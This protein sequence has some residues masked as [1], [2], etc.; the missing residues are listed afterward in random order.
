[1]NILKNHDASKSEA[2]FLKDLSMNPDFITP[3]LLSCSTRNAKFSTIAIQCLNKLILARAIP[4]SKLDLLLDAFIEATH[5]AID[6]QLKVLQTLPTLFQIYGQFINNGLVAKLLLICSMLQSPGKIPMVINTSAATQQQI[7]LSLFDKVIEEDKTDVVKEFTVSIDENEKLQISSNAYDAYHV[8]NDLCSL[9][10]HQKPSFLTFK[11]MPETF[12]FELLENV[13]INYQDVF[14]S[15]VE[16]G[17]LVRTR[18]TPLL[19]RSFSNHKDFLIVVRVSRIMLLLIRT[20]IS[21]L[22]LEAEVMLSLLT[23]VV[24]KDSNVPYWKKVLSLEVFDGILSD[25]DLTKYIFSSYDYH[26]DK[27]KLIYNFLSVCSDIVKEGWATKL[28]QISDIV[29]LP[30]QEHAISAQNSSL[31][32]PYIEL[33][34]KNEAPPAPKTYTL[35]LILSCAN[36]ISEG[37]GNHVRSLSTDDS[38]TFTFL[39]ELPSDEKEKNN[40]LQLKA[41][42]TANAKSIISIGAEFLYSSLGNE[43]FHALIRALQKLCHAAG[44]LGLTAERDSL[45]LLFSVATISNNVKQH[46]K[47]LSIGET[48]VETFNNTIV[49]TPTTPHAPAIPKFHQRYLNS[50]H[51][52]CFR[53]LVSLV[54]SLGPTLK[55][56]WGF[57]LATFQ[58]FD[59]Y[60]NGPSATLSF[61][62]IPQKPD[63]SNNDLKIAESSFAKLFESTADYESEA[64]HEA[65]EE[66]I[67]LTR[68]AAFDKIINTEPMLEDDILLCPY[69]RDFFVKR[70]GDISRVNAK[71]LLGSEHEFWSMVVKILSDICTS[72][73][74]SPGLRVTSCSTFNLTAKN[75]A[76][77]AF[78]SDSTFD[79]NHIETELM[80]SLANL[81]DRMLTSVGD[82]QFSSSESEIFHDTLKTLYELLDRFGT[83]LSHSWEA[84]V[85]IVDCPFKFFEVSKNVSSQK[86]LLKSSFEN[87]QLVLNDF[88]QT[89]PL[90]TMI[91][92]IDVLQSFCTQQYELNISF[93]AISYYWL[94][95]DYFRQSSN[96]ESKTETNVSSRDDLLEIIRSTPDNY[97]QVHCLW[98]YLLNSLVK[99]SNDPRSEVRNG[100]MQ[101][102]FR[103][104]DSH[105]SYLDWDKTYDI[106]VKELLQIELNGTFA[107]EA[108]R[109]AAYKDSVSIVLKGLTELYCRFFKFSSEVVYWNGLLEFFQRLVN[110][111]VTEISFFVYK[112]FH[113]IVTALDKVSTEV[114]DLLYSF[115]GSQHI[116][117]VV[118]DTDAYQNCVVELIES[119]GQLY[120]FSHISISQLESGL[121]IFNNAIR[122]PFLPRF[123]KDV[124]KPTKLQSAVIES[125]QVIDSSKN[126]E[127]LSLLLLHMA[128]IVLLPFQT[129]SRIVKKLQGKGKLEVPSFIA[130]SNEALIWIEHIL[131]SVEDFEPLV[132]NKSSQ[133]VFKNLLEAVQSK[134]DDEVHQANILDRTLWK[135]ALK[136]LLLLSSKAAPLLSKEESDEEEKQMSRELWEHIA[137]SIVVS[138]PVGNNDRDEVFNEDIYQRFKKSIS[139]YIGKAEVPESVLNKLITSVWKSSFLYENDEIEKYLLKKYESPVDVSRSLLSTHFNDYTTETIKVLPQ[140][141]LRTLCLEDLFIFSKYENES[142]VISSEDIKRISSKTLPYLVCRL[143]L[144][145]KKFAGSQ[146][147]LHYAPVPLVQQKEL[148]LSL[149]Q[150]KILMTGITKENI[151]E[152]KPLWD[153]YPYILQNMA[154]LS[155]NDK[156]AEKLLTK[157]IAEF[158]KLS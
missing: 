127:I 77:V 13:L 52:I 88:L 49:S 7:V 118:S 75:L 45:L 68:S 84:V 11:I 58:W 16:L 156:E 54:I 96:S 150:L 85:H 102:F 138:L 86:Q 107:N 79:T 3:F 106:V 98:L 76:T 57:V 60:L 94:I 157:I 105:G 72:H 37:I 148:I 47:S 43:L 109:L 144:S 24:S 120:K 12:G 116:T 126:S 66:F 35:Y 151:G 121:S 145:F 136:I 33:L 133:K 124:L 4:I 63:L 29:M 27:K 113:D 123:T 23:H 101:T 51:I 14:L 44:V 90:K 125:L 146:K 91:N 28:L 158:Y 74:V 119:F 132:F 1:M 53:A 103:I 142:I 112:S 56:S 78:A 147:L 155:R 41:L 32:I 111:N 31:K 87:L 83:H 19:L 153:I 30:S 36:S 122:F 48:I 61:N 25:F 42:L 2:V 128:T 50:R 99:I 115:W 69:N 141:H 104:V 117:Y 21:I 55:K 143:V 137:E 93:S 34:D 67:I 62:E 134:V 46:H 154:S 18:I 73:E 70:I 100:A 139:P 81:V 39:N 92:I 149:Q 59:Y 130:V 140:Q 65:L 82:S 5:L 89:V 20:Q 95:S 80:N 15:H 6:I 97:S 8:L 114:F 40:I 71:R 22:E 26:D 38:N 10:E 9:V 17:F 135:K 131:S 129:R 108:E 64:F 110:W 152:Y